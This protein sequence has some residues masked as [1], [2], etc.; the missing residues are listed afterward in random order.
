M[1]AGSM[2]LKMRKSPAFYRVQLNVLTYDPILL[3][4][5]YLLCTVI[6]YCASG[7]YVMAM[8]LWCVWC[9]MFD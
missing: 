3:T 7:L 4:Y 5:W 8:F 2:K 9:E 1:Y 6:L